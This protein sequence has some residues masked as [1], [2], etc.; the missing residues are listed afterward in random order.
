MTNY[1][2]F[3]TDPTRDGVS[4]VLWRQLTG[5]T[6]VSGGSLR[7]NA[8]SMV[9]YGDILRGNFNFSVTIPTAPAS[10]DSKTFGIKSI[11][12]G[13]Q[14]VFNITDAVFSV[15]TTNSAGTTTTTVVPWRSAWTATP[16]IFS[17]KWEAGAVKFMIGGRII[18]YHDGISGSP[19]SLYL[20]N[21]DADNMD[22]SYITATGVESYM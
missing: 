15:K 8:A 13:T 1:T 21:T 5:T 2:N 4:A 20:E 6:T 22:V 19:M 3:I 12:M 18:A 10:G 17:I 11:A 9:S 14:A 16:A 7:L